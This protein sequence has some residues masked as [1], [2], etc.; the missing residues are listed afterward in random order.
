[1]GLAMASVRVP[2]SFDVA[3]LNHRPFVV[4]DDTIVLRNSFG[5]L[6]TPHNSQQMTTNS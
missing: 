6:R 5:G 2:A 1:M 4:S 3:I